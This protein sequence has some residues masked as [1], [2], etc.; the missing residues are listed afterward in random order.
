[1]LQQWRL[2]RF[3]ASVFTKRREQMILDFGEEDEAGDDLQFH[4]MS[5][6]SREVEF[7][8]DIQVKEDK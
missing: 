3:S 4:A 8:E 7:Y 1:M 6:N 5:K 2:G